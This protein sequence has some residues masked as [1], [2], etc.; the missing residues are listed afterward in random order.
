[1]NKERLTLTKLFSFDAA[2][3]LE[4]YPG[5]CK[6]I[7]GHTY[8]LQVTIT[9]E[10]KNE[11]NHPFNGMIIDFSELK[12]WIQ[13]TV[14]QLFDHALLLHEDSLTANLDFP[15]KERIYFTTYAP[16]CENMLLDIV[17]RLKKCVPTGIQ[18]CEVR[19]QE[20]PTSFATWRSQ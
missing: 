17:T 7:H 14:L 10:V 16:T 13:E 4:N 19:L 8:N 18:L 15:E 2:H 3:V 6:H 5:K 12:K 20:T 11:M 9:G 1:M